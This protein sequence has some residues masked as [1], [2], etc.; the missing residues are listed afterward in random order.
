MSRVVGYERQRRIARD[1]RV[2]LLVEEGLEADLPD[3]LDQLRRRSPGRLF[4]EPHDVGAGRR[5]FSKL[6]G[7]RLRDGAGSKGDRES[8]W[9]EDAPGQPAQKQV[10]HRRLHGL[11]DARDTRRRH[12]RS[13]CDWVETR[14]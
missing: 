10:D 3:V 11:T 7:A 9:G 14:R 13:R 6:L 4:E 1:R 8:G 12:D 2:E 5:V